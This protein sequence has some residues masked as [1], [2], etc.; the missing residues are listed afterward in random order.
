M[1]DIKGHFQKY[2]A[3]KITETNIKNENKQ[4]RKTLNSNKKSFSSKIKELLES[5][6]IQS[7]KVG[8]FF[9]RLIKSQTQGKIEEKHVNNK[10]VTLAAKA[11]M[12][13]IEDRLEP[14]EREKFIE[15]IADLINKNRTTTRTSV[16]MNKKKPKEASTLPSQQLRK[17]CNE[18]CSITTE[19]KK[20][21]GIMRKALKD[22]NINIKLHEEAITEYLKTTQ[23]K[24]ATLVSSGVNYKV[25]VKDTTRSKKVTKSDIVDIIK[26]VLSKNHAN[27]G[28]FLQ[29]VLK[30]IL[31]KQ[32]PSK[33]T[34]LVYTSK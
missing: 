28:K 7:V 27:N 33:G 11:L 10:E 18:Y 20:N 1:G 4:H 29:F 8:D 16:T 26:N 14:S 25:T 30:Q 12:K 2:L 32:S 21:S 31:K 17:I 5:E 24:S 15:E 9:V 13:S 19:L 34:R 6:N 22:T 23:T 3:Y